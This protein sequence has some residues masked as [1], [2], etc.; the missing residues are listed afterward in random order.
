MYKTSTYEDE[1]INELQIE[2]QGGYVF[3]V[4]LTNPRRKSP[5]AVRFSLKGQ[6]SIIT[7][8][9]LEEYD[10]TVR[11]LDFSKLI[12]IVEVGAGFGELIP[13]ALKVNPKLPKPIVIDPVSYEPLL[14]LIR[15]AQETQLGRIP[16]EL[17]SK[18]EGYARRIEFYLSAK[19]IHVKKPVEEAIAEI[20]ELRGI[21]DVVIDHWATRYY[22]QDETN[23]EKLL[24]TGGRI[25]PPKGSEAT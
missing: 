25:L 9:D 2:G 24:K 12:Q 7:G 21:A 3:C 5:P 11:T 15:F 6:D 17:H 4:F 14:D 20:P 23:L 22:K 18:I 13:H 19:V 10:P 16:R 1:F 8:R